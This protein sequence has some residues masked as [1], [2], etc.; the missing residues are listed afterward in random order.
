MGKMR[1]FACIKCGVPLEVHPPDSVH[2]YASRDERYCERSIK[3]EHQCEKCGAS[4][5]IF[6]CNFVFPD[7]YA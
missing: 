5:I 4:N 1:K 3:V 7:W 2:K 6:W